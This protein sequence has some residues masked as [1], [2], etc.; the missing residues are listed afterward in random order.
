ME[1]KKADN[2][3]NPYYKELSGLIAVG[4]TNLFFAKS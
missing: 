1:R 4:H 3:K 2:Y